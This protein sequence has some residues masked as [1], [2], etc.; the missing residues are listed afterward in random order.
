MRFETVT[1]TSFLQLK[2]LIF[3]LVMDLYPI[4]LT[5]VGKRLWHVSHFEGNRCY[6]RTFH[7]K[8][9]DH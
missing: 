8:V 9:K 2:S 5:R 1:E 4:L 6:Q 7:L 3:T